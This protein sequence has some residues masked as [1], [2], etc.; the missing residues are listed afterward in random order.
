MTSTAGMSAELSNLP[1]TLLRAYSEI[2]GILARLR[3]SR[4]VLEQAAVDR[5]TLMNDKLKEVSSATETAATDMLNGLDRTIE[6]VNELNALADLPDSAARGAEVRGHLQDE[7]F[8]LM[9]HLQFQDITTQQLAYASSIIAEME[10]RLAQIVGIFDAQSSD[11][12][13]ITAA[14]TAP[15]GP[16]TFDPHATTASATNRQ[17]LADEIFLVNR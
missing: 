6:M 11:M 15:H 9:I 1:K 8:G 5:L 14:M 16:K 7:L 4:G 10:Q 2:T 17:L 13:T 3:E 12:E